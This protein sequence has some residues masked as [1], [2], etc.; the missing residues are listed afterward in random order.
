MNDK[1]MYILENPED[2][3]ECVLSGILHTLDTSDGSTTDTPYCTAA[4]KHLNDDFSKPEWCPLKKVPSRK[5]KSICN[6]Q[7]CDGFNDCLDEILDN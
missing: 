3:F 4:D 6:D 5:D 2:C 7:Y 1:Y